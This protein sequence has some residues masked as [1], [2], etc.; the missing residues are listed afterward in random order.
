VVGDVLA[1]PDPLAV[2]LLNHCRVVEAPRLLNVGR[3]QVGSHEPILLSARRS[4]PPAGQFEALMPRPAGS[5]IATY[6]AL[7]D[8]YQEAPQDRRP[9]ER[10]R[11]QRTSPRKSAQGVF[12]PA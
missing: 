1:V 9:S 4:R 8:Q 12:F 3:F 7:N 6:C 10:N 11:G 2:R 5:W